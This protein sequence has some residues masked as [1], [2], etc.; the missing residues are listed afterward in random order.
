MNTLLL[1][2]V[3]QGVYI[4]GKLASTTGLA[5]AQTIKLQLENQ[6]LQLSDLEQEQSGLMEEKAA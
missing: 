2:G 1:L 6:K 4:G 3:S 5:K